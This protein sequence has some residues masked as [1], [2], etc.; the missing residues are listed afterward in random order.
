[1]SL[2]F[3]D[4]TEIAPMVA[5][6]PPGA[7]P[8]QTQVGGLECAAVYAEHVPLIPESEWKNRI[9][10]MAASG[11]FIGQRWKS[12]AKADYQNGTPLCHLYSLA[13]AVMAKRHAMGLPFVQLAPESGLGVNG[14]RLA[15]GYLDRDIE[16]AAVHGLCERSYVPM[17]SNKPNSWKAGWAD[18]ALNNIPLE[19]WDLDGQNVWASTV[20]ALLSGDGC[21]VG[22]DWAGH[23]VFLDMLRVG[24]NGK[25][26][27]HTPNSHGP[28]QDWW[29]A[30]SKAIPSMGSFVIRSVTFS[31]AT[32]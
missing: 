11:S 19:W 14:Y 5:G 20:T 15:G 6:F 32:L 7:L 3:D 22:Y 9:A 30:G 31:G 18:N 21:Y 2:F 24:T 29:L 12:D 4:E 25:I 16:W 10:D 8:R 27:V 17:Y 28:G 1:M 13:Q 23:A 26:E